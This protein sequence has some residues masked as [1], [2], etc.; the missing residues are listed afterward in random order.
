MVNAVLADLKGPIPDQDDRRVLTF[1]FNNYA[2]IIGKNSYSNERIVKEHPHR[3][4]LWLHAMAARGSHVILCVHE[5]PEPEP[6]IIQYAAGLAL[7]NSHS[8]ARTVSISLL[9]DVFKPHD[10]GIGIWKTKRSI[11]VEVD[12]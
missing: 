6:T 7:K 12:E 1:R 3:D 11:S 2:I 8:Q 4:C 5:M 9:K 10:S